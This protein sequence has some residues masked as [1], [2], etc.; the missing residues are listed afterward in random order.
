MSAGLRGPAVLLLLAG[1]VFVGSAAAGFVY[2][3]DPQPDRV[4]VRLSDSAP[5][6]AERFVGGTIV[7][8][9]A[10]VIELRTDAGVVTIETPPGTPLEELLPAGSAE[11]TVGTP[12]NLGGRRTAESA[13]LSGLVALET[14]GM[15]P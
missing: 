14:P 9:A 11:L 6:G 3:H 15:A 10:G 5:G 2:A 7:S 1:A 13:V 8:A 12:V 4:T